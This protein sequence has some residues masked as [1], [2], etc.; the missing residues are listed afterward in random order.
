VIFPHPQRRHG[1][2]SLRPSSQFRQRKRR[3]RKQSSSHADAG[4]AN[5]HRCTLQ[6]VVH[7]R[8]TPANASHSAAARKKSPS[9]PIS[10]TLL[11]PRDRCEC[12]VL[13]LHHTLW[14]YTARAITT[15]TLITTLPTP[16]LRHSTLSP[17]STIAFSIPPPT[18]V[19][20]HAR[21]YTRLI[22]NLLFILNNILRPCSS[23]DP[24]ARPFNLD[25]AQH[26]PSILR[27]QTFDA[28]TTIHIQP[29]RTSNPRRRVC[30]CD[31][32]ASVVQAH[33]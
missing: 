25:P 31:L 20:I 8:D 18:T 7:P 24:G 15:T 32:R 29:L 30:A 19:K 2:F 16:T 23:T 6:H 28:C 33:P 11:W 12:I 21:K 10:C 3:E 26:H 13:Y 1:Q 27:G 14:E 17:G 5:H 22:D 9:H 4:T